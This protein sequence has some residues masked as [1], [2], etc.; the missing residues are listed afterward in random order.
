MVKQNKAMLKVAE[1]AL[2]Y[3][4]KVIFDEKREGLQCTFIL[5]TLASSRRIAF[6]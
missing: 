5:M 1:N 2:E 6:I 3:G 4:I